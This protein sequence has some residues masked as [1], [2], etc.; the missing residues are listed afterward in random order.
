MPENDS[1]EIWTAYAKG[2]KPLKPVRG[3]SP[4]RRKAADSSSFRAA[5]E[6]KPRGEKATHSRCTDFHAPLDHNLERRLRQ[7]A[8]TI[9][10]RLDLHGMY[11]EEAHRALG[12]LIARHI[13]DGRRYLLIITG[14]GRGGEGVLRANLAGWLAGLPGAAQILALRGASAKHG[15]SGAFYIV[16]KRRRDR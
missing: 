13:K 15:G 9:E 3:L 14:K 7:G 1:D 12:D 8:M 5:G 2:V 6:K 16:L 11:Q 10:A 4:S